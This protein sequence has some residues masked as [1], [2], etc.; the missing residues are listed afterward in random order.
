[1]LYTDLCRL[2]Q[3]GAFII[4]VISGFIGPILIKFAQDVAKILPF[5]ICK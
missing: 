5:I 3:K 4:L 2:V 1:M